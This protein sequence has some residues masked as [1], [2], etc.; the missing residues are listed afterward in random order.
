MILINLETGLLLGRKM[1]LGQERTNHSDIS[2]SNSVETNSN[3][4]S[5]C[6]WQHN[7][8]VSP[9]NVYK[10]STMSNVACVRFC[11]WTEWSVLSLTFKMAKLIFHVGTP[12]NRFHLLFCHCFLPSSIFSNSQMVCW[13]LL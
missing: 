5:F 2:P 3:A 1:V 7:D 6:Q 13:Q 11:R 8:F 4:Y 10:H 12:C 9:M